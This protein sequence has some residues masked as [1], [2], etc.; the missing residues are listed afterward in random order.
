MLP[1][2]AARP[3]PGHALRAQDDVLEVG[4]V[5][6]VPA[7]LGRLEERRVEDAAR[8]VDQDADRTE[9]G[10]RALEGG[11]DLARVPYVDGAGEPPTSSAAAAAVSAWR[12]QMATLAPKAVNPLAMP[13]PIPEPPPVTTATRS[14]SR[15]SEGSMGM[16]DVSVRDVPAESQRPPVRPGGGG[17]CAENRADSAGGDG[18]G[19]AAHHRRGGGDGLYATPIPLQIFAYKTQ[20]I[21]MTNAARMVWGSSHCSAAGSSSSCGSAVPSSASASP[22][23]SRASTT[24]SPTRTSPAWSRRAAGAERPGAT[25]R[26]VPRPALGRPPRHRRRGL[27]TAG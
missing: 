25:G 18:A 27:P 5:E 12:S 23:C 15:T 13:R 21:L 24:P 16:T 17:L 4:A 3:S 2:I 26:R 14:V 20:Q 22:A 11:V 6:G 1:A 8:V 9:L 7:V 10:D 19:A